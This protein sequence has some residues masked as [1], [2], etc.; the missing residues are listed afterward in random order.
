MRH[1]DFLIKTANKNVRKSQTKF[2][3][4]VEINT[5]KLFDLQ[6]ECV[7]LLSK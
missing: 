5:T 4:F 7:F 2:M 1:I 6:I 3:I